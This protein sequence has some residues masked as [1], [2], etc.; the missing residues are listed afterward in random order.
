MSSC[1]WGSALANSRDACCHAAEQRHYGTLQRRP[2]SSPSL[3]AGCTNR[4]SPCRT[5]TCFAYLSCKCDDILSQLLCH[6]I[7]SLIIILLLLLVA[8]IFSPI[9]G[10]RFLPGVP[11]WE[12]GFASSPAAFLRQLLSV[13]QQ[14][15]QTQMW[16][17]FQR[18]RLS[19]GLCFQ[20]AW[21]RW[22]VGFW[23]A[24]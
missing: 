21:N 19:G 4:Q 1:L 2:L 3:K 10:Q 24:S 15:G 23:G 5:R 18:S 6:L 20:S 12:S 17:A 22:R 9:A 7:R 14:L 8:L 11:L 13:R 16:R